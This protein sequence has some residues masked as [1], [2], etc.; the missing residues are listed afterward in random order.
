MAI[1]WR[2]G[3]PSAWGATDSLTTPGSRPIFT[4]LPGEIGEKCSRLC[5]SKL[6]HLNGGSRMPQGVSRGPQ[7]DDGADVER[8]PSMRPLPRATGIKAV[9]GLWLGLVGLQSL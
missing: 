6:A 2:R 4:G 3:A 7:M 1:A 9:I 5:I 8:H